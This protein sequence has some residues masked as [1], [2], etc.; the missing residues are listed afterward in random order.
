M[1]QI[2]RALSFCHRKGIVHRDI[3][4]E[5]LLLDK[6]ADDAIIKVIDFGTSQFTNGRASLKGRFGTLFYVAPEVLN[7][8]YNFKCDIWSA[9]V[10]LYILL[11]GQTPFNGRNNKEVLEKIRC[12]RFGFHG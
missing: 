6:S 7:N 12:G 1:V 2:L 10:I 4:P 11:S 3:K 9:G 8:N 5:N